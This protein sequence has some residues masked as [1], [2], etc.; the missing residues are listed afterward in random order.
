MFNIENIFFIVF[1]FFKNQP[2]K[3]EN[4]TAEVT[5]TSQ[6]IPIEKSEC[7][8]DDD[9]ED[10]DDDDMEVE[11][12]E[13]VEE[14]SEEEEETEREKYEKERKRDEV[15]EITTGKIYTILQLDRLVS[16]IKKICFNFMNFLYL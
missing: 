13:E 8:D 6:V 14:E 12:E 16:Y 5:L 7:S 1:F 9:D 11:T 2:S 10:D 3:K 15:K 4:K